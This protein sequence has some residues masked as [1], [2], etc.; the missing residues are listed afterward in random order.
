MS[1]KNK[2]RRTPLRRGPWQAD[3]KRFSHLIVTSWASADG[4]R[5]SSRRSPNPHAIA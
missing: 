3:E 2:E 1:A 5:R 4:F